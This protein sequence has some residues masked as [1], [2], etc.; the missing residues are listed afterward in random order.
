MSIVVNVK[1]SVQH[2]KELPDSEDSQKNEHQKEIQH[3]LF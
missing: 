1:D 3:L 2:T